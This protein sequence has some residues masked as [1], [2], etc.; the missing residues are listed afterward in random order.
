MKSFVNIHSR[1]SVYLLVPLKPAISQDLHIDE[2]GA[3]LN[4]GQYRLA[5]SLIHHLLTRFQSWRKSSCVV[6][7]YFQSSSRLK[8]F[9]V[10]GLSM[11]KEAK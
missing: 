2:A 8:A 1:F 10:R 3:N 11:Q 4:E 6:L 9:S 5:F 7:L